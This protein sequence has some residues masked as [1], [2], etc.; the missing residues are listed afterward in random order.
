MVPPR[1]RSRFRLFYVGIREGNAFAHD[2]RMLGSPGVAGERVLSS[3]G[4]LQH[5]RLRC[6]RYRY[7]TVVTVPSPQRFRKEIALQD[8]QIFGNRLVVGHVRDA[9]QRQERVLTSG[10]HQRLAQAQAV[11]DRHIVVGEPWM[12]MSG[13]S[14]AAR[15][16]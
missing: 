14:S 12:S 6:C 4:A 11:R 5:F 1:L 8:Q 7:C 16:R 13:R 2:V 3:Y 15:R 9:G 10:C